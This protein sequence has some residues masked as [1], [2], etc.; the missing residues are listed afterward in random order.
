M[1]PWFEGFDALSLTNSKVD[2]HP[3]AE[4]HRVM[5]EHMANDIASYIASKSSTTTMASHR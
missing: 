2:S 4:G 1:A 3:N 5:A